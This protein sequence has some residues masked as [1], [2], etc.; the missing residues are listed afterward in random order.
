M[1][2]SQPVALVTGGSG[3]IGQAI[4]LRLSL[5]GCRV[6]V[7]YQHN[8]AA[9]AQ[10]CAQIQAGGGQAIAIQADVSQPEHVAAMFAT[11]QAAF[12][13]VDILVNNAGL[14]HFGLI[15]DITPTEWRRLFAVNV[16]GAFHCIQSALPSMV[17][18][19]Q[20]C[21]INISSIWG[22]VG[23]SCEA[24]YSATKGA[25]IALSKALA[26]ELGPS[27]VR[28]NCVAPG[29]IETAMNSRLNPTELAGL[30]EE[31]P[32]GCIG[33]PQDVAETV[34]WLASDA[35]RF[36]TGQVISPNGGFTIY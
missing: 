31:T 12:G 15:T 34:A 17:H 16:D 22:I 21:I 24:A 18:N 4:A 32:L 5:A 6:L 2:N 7:N 20:G 33:Q 27:G 19:K 30:R 25:M 36:I 11:A 10:L 1:S 13:P 14:S 9:T 29:V 26:K 23:G 35:A 3:G 8:E 28:V